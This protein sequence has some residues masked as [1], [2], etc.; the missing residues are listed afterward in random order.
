LVRTR[1]IFALLGPSYGG[2][3]MGFSLFHNWQIIISFTALLFVLIGM[4]VSLRTK[5]LP[6][7]AITAFTFVYSVYYLVFVSVV[8][9]WYCIPLAAVAIMAAGIGLDAALRDCFAT[10]WRTVVAYALVT[11][12]LFSLAV[13]APASFRDEKRIQAFVE[14]GVRKQIGLYLA[15]HMGPHQ[16]IGC[17]PLGYIGYYSRHVIYD[18]PGLCNWKAAQ[19]FHHHPLKPDP[20]GGYTFRRK[21]LM[22]SMIN[23]LAHFRPDYIV[24]RPEEYQTAVDN[25]QD[26]LLAEYQQ[27]AVF[28]V[29]D[30]DRAQLL[31][32]KDNIDL[33][34][35][36]FERRSDVPRSSP[37]A[38]ARQN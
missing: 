16:T 4:A 24:L 38:S 20:T 6:A 10:P 29:S 18:F 11:A 33:E 26:W 37:A 28:R 13:Y 17:E 30:E 23:M 22:T 3:G 2:H 19:Y 5:S 35:H 12:F 32:P 7:L 36:V 1:R 34:Y 8:A 31:F 25:H 27:V 9:P 14:D 21:M 15:A